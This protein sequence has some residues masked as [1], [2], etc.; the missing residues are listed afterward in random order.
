M[1]VKKAAIWLRK[2]RLFHRILRK[3]IKTVF[4]EQWV[5]LFSTEGARWRDF[6]P[7]FPPRDRIWADPFL[8]K[9]GGKVFVFYEE[10]FLD[11]SRGRISCVEMDGV[12][13]LAHF[14]VLERPYHLSYPF[15]FEYNSQLYMLPE[16]KENRQ[17]ELY[18]CRRFPD[19]WVFER[20]LMPDVEAVDSTLVKFN[21]KWWLFTT[22]SSKDGSN[23]KEISLFFA[24]SP[25][26]AAWHAHPKN[27]IVQDVRN[28]RSAGRIF[29][30]NGDLIRPAQ[31]CSIRYG[32]ATNFNRILMLTEENYEE[33]LLFTFK[34]HFFSRYYATH[35]WNEA[36]DARVIDAQMWRVKERRS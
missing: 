25:L 35:T 2:P 3:L 14:T 7:L 23:R 5:L 34:P 4:F 10:Q 6:I 27:P 36:G 21:G 18:R 9:K 31:D 29:M 28:A 32:Y 15:L 13:P 8:W 26:S 19:D 16:S 24:D 22:L 12:H 20:V 30:R 17:I 11:T 1:N 33:R